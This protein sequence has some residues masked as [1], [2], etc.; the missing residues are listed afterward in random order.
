MG[1]V[2]KAEDTKLK[3]NI[4]LKFLPPELIRDAEARERFVLEARAAAALSHPSICT[5]HEIHEE[6]GD[7]FIAMEYIE[8][9]SL[10][11]RMKEAPPS[12]EEAVDIAIQVAEGLEEAHKKGIIHRDIKSANIMVTDQGQAKIMDFGLAKVKGGTLLT[13]E[14]TTLGTVAY[15]SPEQARGEEVDHRSD[16]WSLGVVLYEMLSGTLPF[17]GEREAS[18]LYSVVHEEPKPLKA[19]KTDIPVE[20]QHIVDRALKKKPDSR[21]SSSS[22]T[23]KDLK[24]YRDSLREG[25]PGAFSFPSFVRLIRRPVVVVPTIAIITAAA[26]ALV[27]FFNRQAKVRWAIEQAVPEINRLIDDRDFATAFRLVEK[28]EKYAPKEPR[29]IALLPRLER[30]LSFQTTPPGADIYLYDETDNGWRR[31]GRSPVE[32]VRTA[33][34]YRR[35]KIEKE[36]FETVEGATLTSASSVADIN[37]KLDEK[38]GLPPGMIRMPGGEFALGLVGMDHLDARQIDEYLIDKFEVTNKEFKAFVDEGGYANR[39]YWTHEFRKDGGILSWEEAMAEFKDRTGR[40]GPSTWET[41]TYPDAQ[42]N[43]PVTGVSWYEAA[44]YAE[45]AGKSLPTISHWDRAADPQAANFILPLSNFNGTG[46]SPVG[47]HQGIAS[48]GAHDMAGNVREWCWNEGENYYRYILG[49]GWNDQVYMF[50]W[51]YSQPPF[52]RSLI[53]GFRCV[54]Y[55]G[56]D[57]NVETLRSSIRLPYRDYMKE[58]PVPDE[59]F[60]IYLGMYRYD[61]AELN[62]VVESVDEQSADFW[63]EK[64]S[65]SAAY[66]GERVIAYLYLPKTGNPPYQA[67]VFFPGS[68]AL[69][70]RSSASL[71]SLPTFQTCDF[72]VKS[73]RVLIFPVYKGTY[74]RESNLASSIPNETVIYKEHVIQWAKDL[75]RTV[76]YLETRTDIDT[77]KLAYYGFSWG[78]RLGGILLAAE[79]RFKTGLLSLGGFRFQKQLPEVD[80]LNFVPRIKIPVLMLNGRY[81]HF[82]PYDTAQIPMFSLLATPPEDKRHVVYDTGHFVPRTQLIKETLDWL[83]R[84]LG[85][86]K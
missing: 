25:K 48:Y 10:R 74:E 69:D 49:G 4:A 32:K 82:F 67:V 9:Q 66:G 14:G 53:N 72:I 30:H 5:I 63:K 45:F 37:I 8:G 11:A 51:A 52:D 44:A 71:E 79:K 85:P 36:R 59:I 61:Q 77:E 56:S 6:K 23:L 17:I 60:N 28:V 42:D 24:N 75:G 83:D 13:R 35:W 34:G 20:L 78:A 54:K 73:G 81:D 39:K 55:L 40:S 58:K 19:I 50:N 29:L 86:V 57:D 41:S 22:E 15:M 18:I 46:P 70:Q 76:D 68:A 64:I 84:Y 3:R 1:I 47:S 27:W 16:I 80:P 65:F 43:Y 38:G 7:S 21:Y 33:A 26:A 62:S 31:V 2:Y 12:L